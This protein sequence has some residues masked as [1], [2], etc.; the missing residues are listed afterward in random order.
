MTFELDHA[1][2]DP[3]HCL[4]PGLFRALGNGERMRL[5]LAVAHRLSDKVTIEFSGPEPLDAVDLRV[6]QG[7]VA[8]AGPNGKTL[9]SEPKSEV[10][11][12]LRKGLVMLL[13]DADADAL[14][15]R[16]SFRN[17]AKEIGYQDVENTRIIRESVERLWKVSVVRQEAGK[18]K[19]YRLLSFYASD[20]TSSL[21]RLTVALNPALA[22]SVLGQNQHTR[23]SLIEVRA[24]K[25]NVTR[26]IHQ[27]LCG[28]VDA[29]ASRDVSL[30]TLVGYA[31]PDPSNNPNTQKSRKKAVKAGLGELQSLGWGVVE[32]LAE[33]YSI[34]R[35]RLG[36]T[37]SFTTPHSLFYDTPVP[38]LRHL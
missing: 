27:R 35:P 30:N 17:L 19:G 28:W 24:I 4:A 37:T 22:R 13:D 29:G 8:I 1:R 32:Y 10:G 26:L 7:L 16:C 6:L 25:A 15:V 3:G 11:T 33:K 34:R 2:H 18:R 9:T 36:E 21:G 12:A 31:W 23:I 14:V 20:E 38:V 5:K